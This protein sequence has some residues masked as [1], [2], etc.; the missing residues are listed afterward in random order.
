MAYFSN[1]PDEII[2]FMTPPTPAHPTLT[3]MVPVMTQTTPV[4]VLSRGSSQANASVPMSSSMPTTS[5]TVAW[6]PPYPGSTRRSKQGQPRRPR[7]QM[8]FRAMRMHCPGDENIIPLYRPDESNPDNATSAS[9]SSGN[10]VNI[11]DK[12]V[13]VPA[14]QPSLVS[15]VTPARHTMTSQVSVAA[16]KSDRGTQ[17]TSEE[18]R[19]LIREEEERDYWM[20]KD[21]EEGVC[22]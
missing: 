8:P 20:M 1:Q 18:Q 16:P 3:S 17:M 21:L 5:Q 19:R 22:R 4:P 12:Q 13:S 9:T 11:K 7:R 14:T 10:V 2:L 6:T 15:S